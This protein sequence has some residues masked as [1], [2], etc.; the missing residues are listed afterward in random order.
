MFEWLST[1][2]R[3]FV[4]GPQRSG[5]R[6]CAKMISHDTGY[7]FIDE[8]RISMDSV[9]GFSSFLESKRKYV[10]QCPTLCRYIHF[11]ASKE[12]AVVLMRRNCKD[13]V[14]SQKRIEWSKEWLE[15]MRYD[16]SRGIISEIKYDF[17]EKNQK[18][19]IQNNYEIE[20][21]S[22]RTHPFWIDK[23]ERGNFSAMQIEKTSS[24]DSVPIHAFLKRAPEAELYF[25]KNRTEGILLD[26]NNIFHLINKTSLRIWEMCDGTHS[27]KDVF[28]H[29]ARLFPEIAKKTLS[30][31]IDLFIAELHKKH[32]I[33]FIF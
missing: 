22:L 31:D 28:G 14:Q 19:K 3:I 18:K 20:Y 8:T 10:I 5:T 12:D 32:F 25:N 4:T 15:L 30:H 21:D 1:F 27:K 13:I 6:I 26:K 24:S 7:E 29:L 9:Y 17:W 2:E 16:R 11:L 33:T 23:K